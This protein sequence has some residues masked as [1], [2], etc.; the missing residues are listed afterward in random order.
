MPLIEQKADVVWQGNLRDG[1]G[2]LTVATVAFPQQDVTFKARTEGGEKQTTPEELIAAAHAACYSM[3]FSNYLSQTN[4]T[5]PTTL[6]TTATTALDRVEG[7][8]KIT[9]IQ[10]DVEGDVPGVDAGDFQ[11]LAEE[12]E[13][14][15]PVS[16]ALRGNVEIA[17]NAK[18]M[19]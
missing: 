9:R 18:L 16:N 15:C 10:L 4:K 19:S 2:K 7:G 1:S 12:A 8:L 11:R 13:Q 17:V 6:H 3:A 14:R 5:P